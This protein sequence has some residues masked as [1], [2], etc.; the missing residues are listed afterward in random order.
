MSVPAHGA[1]RPANPSKA[2][3]PDWAR[4]D[5]LRNQMLRMGYQSVALHANTKVPAA[6]GWQR[7]TGMPGWHA[8]TANTGML[9]AGLGVIDVEVDG[10]DAGAIKDSVLSRLGPAPVPVPVQTAPGSAAL[11]GR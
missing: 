5:G 3:A 8:S 4:V 2:S 9:C 1:T 7:T 10:Q 11:P 6:A